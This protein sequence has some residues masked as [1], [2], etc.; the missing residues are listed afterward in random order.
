MTIQMA[1]TVTYE[2]R[3]YLVWTFPLK[4]YYE[5]HPRPAFDP[6]HTGLHRGYEAI[7]EVDG[8]T[9]Y[10]TEIKQARVDGARVGVAELVPGREGK[11]EAS[12]FSGQLKLSGA[13]RERTPP[14][15]ERD[16]LLTFNCGKLV[17]SELGEPYKGL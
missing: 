13:V 14:H 17:R 3:R 12:W 4:S 15:R 11:V 2:G 7:W 9:L 8:D 1:D 16:R 5:D 6:C 10:L